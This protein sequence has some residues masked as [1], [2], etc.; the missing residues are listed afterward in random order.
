MF[1]N[2]TIYKQHQQTNEVNDE[3]R[4]RNSGNDSY[5]YQEIITSHL[6][7]KEWQ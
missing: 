4:R 6:F 3:I 1:K 5:L 2:L 7:P